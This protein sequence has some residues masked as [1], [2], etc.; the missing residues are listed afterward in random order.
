MQRQFL[1]NGTVLGRW[2]HISE[3][4]WGFI[5]KFK[6]IFS[7]KLDVA[8][9][10]AQQGGL[11]LSRYSTIVIGD[12]EVYLAL[13][14][15][16]NQF[17]RIRRSFFYQLHQFLFNRKRFFARSPVLPQVG[18]AHRPWRHH[19][20]SKGNIWLDLIFHPCFDKT[21]YFP[22]VMNKTLFNF[23][24]LSEV[25][26]FGYHK[27]EVYLKNVKNDKGVIELRSQRNVT[28]FM[29]RKCCQRHDGPEGWVVLKKPT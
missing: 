28:L 13:V 23:L 5:K 1:R 24:G 21:Q 7:F 17:F 22:L 20:G 12:L 9:I 6:L 16:F 19:R 27:G 15:N 25:R 4:N 29:I 26:H 3:K 18:A 10:M 2:E 8:T 14:A 11:W